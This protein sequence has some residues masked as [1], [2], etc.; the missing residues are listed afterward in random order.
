MAKKKVAKFS[1][2]P[3]TKYSK[4]YAGGVVA[5]IMSVSIVFGWDLDEGSVTEGVQL[6]GTLIGSLLSVYGSA[7]RSD[8]EWY[9][10]RK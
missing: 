8:L 2:D 6:F 5:L 7:A 9:G 3:F 10:K 4:A 1:L